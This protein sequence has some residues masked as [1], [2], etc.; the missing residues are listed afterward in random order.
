MAGN[1]SITFTF[2]S[3]LAPSI[4]GDYTWYEQTVTT[5]AADSYTYQ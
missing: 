5:T 3:W 2:T 1:Q 4:L